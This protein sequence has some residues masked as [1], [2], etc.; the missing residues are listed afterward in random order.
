MIQLAEA[1]LS[2]LTAARGWC[3]WVSG[4]GGDLAPVTALYHVISERNCLQF[5]TKHMFR[6]AGNDIKQ[7]IFQEDIPPKES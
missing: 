5:V 1:G 3:V 4:I 7:F 6:N 2:I